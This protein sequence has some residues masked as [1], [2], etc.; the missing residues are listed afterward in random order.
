MS[1]EVPDELVPYVLKG[2]ELLRPWLRSNGRTIPPEVASPSLLVNGRHSA[3][4]SGDE[5]EGQ[6]TASVLAVTYAEAGRMLHKSSETIGRMVRDGRLRAIG[7]G[8]GKR[9][10]VVELE[11]FITRE[12]E[13]QAS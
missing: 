7:S 10:P 9:I 12:L 3:A 6:D 11:A 8:N 2:W 5:H 4:D 1:V 13:D